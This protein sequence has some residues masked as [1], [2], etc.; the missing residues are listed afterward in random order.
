M[1]KLFW[2]YFDLRIVPKFC[3][4]ANGKPGQECH[5]RQNHCTGEYVCTK[6]D[7]RSNLVAERNR[8]N[9]RR[10]N[11]NTENKRFQQTRAKRQARIRNKSFFPNKG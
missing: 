9:G 3:G 6:V 10:R 7:I 4:R 2:P 5:P 8:S 1:I 11:G